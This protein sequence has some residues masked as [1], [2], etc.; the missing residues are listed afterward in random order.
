MKMKNVIL[1]LLI[2]KKYVGKEF[3]EA[4]EQGKIKLTD[5]DYESIRDKCSDMF[6]ENEI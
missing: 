3:V 6:D 4:L 5:K 1:D 2:S